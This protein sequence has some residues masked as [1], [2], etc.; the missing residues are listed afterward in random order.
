MERGEKGKGKGVEGMGKGKGWDGKARRDRK[1]IGGRQLDKGRRRDLPDQC[2]TASYARVV[3][4][5][6]IIIII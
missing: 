2:Q 4:I 5:T 1:E 3:A 6:I